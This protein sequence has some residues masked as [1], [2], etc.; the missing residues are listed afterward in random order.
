M[1]T[2][3]RTDRGEPA[4]SGAPMPMSG[5]PEGDGQ[6]SIRCMDRRGPT[7]RHAQSCAFCGH[8]VAWVHPLAS[9]LVAYREYGKGHTL[10]T[11]W[12]LCDRCEGIYASG[13]VDAAV[14]VMRASDAWSWVAV[15]DVDECIRKPLDVFRRA[16]LGAR[17]LDE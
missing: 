11:F 5:C 8:E 10:P 1:T 7:S 15:E 14:E 4:A 9:D 16:D 2:V 3:F 13:D 6:A 12:A 17:R